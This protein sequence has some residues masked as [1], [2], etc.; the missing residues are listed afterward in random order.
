LGSIGK[1]YALDRCAER[2]VEEDIH[3]FM[4]HGGQ[5][6]VLARGATA[7]DPLGGWL[8]GVHHPLRHRK[9]LAEIRLRDRALATSGSEKQFFR[10]RGRRLS[11]ILDPRTGR[12]AEG[13][14]SVTVL[15]PTAVLADGLSTAFF[16]MGAEPTMAYCE[17]RPELGV[18]LVRAGRGDRV[19]VLSVGLE[20][21]DVRVLEA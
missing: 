21:R 10:Y 9:R 1:G 12:P 16:V 8:V 14:L 6:S 11:H 18:L 2:M 19:D 5:S 17:A 15:A 13:L 4:I 3:D 20:D 7:G